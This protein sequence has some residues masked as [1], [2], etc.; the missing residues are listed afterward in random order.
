[1]LKETIERLQYLCDI[2]PPLLST[3]S[4]KDFS[5]KP[6][7]NK[8][9]KKEVLGHLIDS[10]ANN[11]QRFVRIQF[12]NE[13]VIGYDQNSWNLISQYNRLDMHHLIKFWEIYNRHL[14]EI[15]KRVP[16]H[17]L[18]LTGIDLNENKATLG[19]LIDDYVAHM[20]HHLRQMVSY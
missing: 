10:A 20:E 3:I 11:H 14:L 9:S 19:F 17:N 2:I 15:M 5:H 16:E 18:G 13:P 8:W 4:E 12:E 6:A 1:M 7:P